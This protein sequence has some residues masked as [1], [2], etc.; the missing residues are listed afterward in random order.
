MNTSTNL[1]NEKIILNCVL[2]NSKQE[3]NTTLKKELN[4]KNRNYSIEVVQCVNCGFIFDNT[5]IDATELNKFYANK[6]EE[7]LK[8]SIEASWWID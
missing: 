6:A 1:I 7:L 8:D 3:V 2:C 5:Y 4:F